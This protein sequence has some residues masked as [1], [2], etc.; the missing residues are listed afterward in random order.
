MEHHWHREPLLCASVV[1]V[2]L[3]VHW[4]LGTDNSIGHFGYQNRFIPHHLEELYEQ[5]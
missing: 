5:R 2:F 4:Q 3:F 1:L